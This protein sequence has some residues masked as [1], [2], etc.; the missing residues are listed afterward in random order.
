METEV[1]VGR[2]NDTLQTTFRR[3]RTLAAGLAVIAALVGA[4]TFC[5]GWWIF[6]NDRQTWAVIGGVLCGLPV[7]AALF[8]HHLARRMIKLAPRLVSDLRSFIDS[9]VHS[10][11]ILIDHD[12]GGAVAGYARSFKT[13]RS[14]L[15]EQRKELPALFA[16]VKAITSVPGLAATTVFGTILIGIL[17]TLLV[18][19]GLLR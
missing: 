16:G 13:M 5:T 2:V 15:R 7:T 14:E 10:A 11:Q 12:T 3:L 1:V 19:G 8:G 17:G 18:V 6:N 4:A 9:S